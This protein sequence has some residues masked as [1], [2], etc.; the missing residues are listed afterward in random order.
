MATR[1]L[2]VD[3]HALFREALARVLSEL[4]PEVAVIHAGTGP[5]AIAAASYYQGLDLILLDRSLAG[6]DGISLL[7]QLRD[8]ANGAPV[9]VIS[10]S[11]RPGDVQRALDAGAA[12]YVPKTVGIQEMLVALRRVLAGDPYLPPT[13]L[14]SL[15]PT[16]HQPTSSQ[17][18][19]LDKLTERQKEVLRL[20]SQG[21]SNKGIANRLD[22]SEGTVKLHVSAIMRA[23]GARNRTE[24]VLVAEQ[25][26]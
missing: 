1:I 3:D 13:L 9:V 5:E 24:A 15:A 17:Q 6:A 19:N 21:L 10:G 12:S 23:L 26:G 16:D 18:I 8:A 11:A 25:F 20:L 22:L 4:D 2:A 7:P 14:A